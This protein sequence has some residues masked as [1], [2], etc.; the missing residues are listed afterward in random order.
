[1]SQDK[2]TI[3]IYIDPTAAI[4]AGNPTSGTVEVPLTADYLAS[5]NTE[6]RELLAKLIRRDDTLGRSWNRRVPAY[7]PYTDHDSHTRQETEVDL[8]QAEATLE[9]VTEVLNVR[10]TTLQQEPAEERQRAIDC[11]DHIEE[12]LEKYEGG[13]GDLTAST[14]AGGTRTWTV[15]AKLTRLALH[16]GHLL[17]DDVATVAATSALHALCKRAETEAGMLNAKEAERLTQAVAREVQKDKEAEEAKEQKRL[18]Y[19]TAIHQWGTESQQERYAVEVLEEAEGL[20]L[21]RDHV[22]SDALASFA[23]YQRLEV[24]DLDDNDAHEEDCSITY[25]D[26]PTKAEVDFDVDGQ[27]YLTDEQWEVYKAMGEAKRAHELLA[28]ATLEPRLHTV[29]CESCGGSYG[30]P[31]V[32]VRVDWHGHRFS[33]EYALPTT[34]TNRPARAG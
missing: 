9:A 22:W 4:L 21:I 19:A 10:L 30:R 28:K 17:T 20:D 23:R 6:Q 34:N 27:S 2:I 26:S 18:A 11:L 25:Y 16:A 7:K 5:L 32:M 8:P 31:S 3:K 33:R 29:T 13:D 1:M 12:T 14:W 15:V 24:S